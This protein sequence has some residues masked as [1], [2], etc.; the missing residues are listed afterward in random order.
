M[1]TLHDSRPELLYLS[2]VVP[3]VTGN[4]LAMRAGTVLEILAQSYSVTLLVVTLYPPFGAAV[5]EV[6]QKLC[7]RHAVIPARRH[8]WLSFLSRLASNGR[9]A[10]YS[11]LDFDVV[12]VFRLAMLPYARRYLARGPVRPARH[13]D[14]DEIESLTHTRIAGLCRANGDEMVA[15]FEEWQAQQAEVAEREAFGQYHRIYVCSE[16]DRSKISGRTRAQVC[17]LPNAVHAVSAPAA[18]EGSNLLF[19]GTLG[20][21]PNDDAARFL[22][23]EIV[24]RIREQ[25]SGV[26][27]VDIVGSGAS[28]R[29]VKAASLDS[30]VHLRG[31]VPDLEPRYRNAAAVVVPIRAG[32]G[33]RIKILEAFSYRRPVV[34]TAAGIEGIDAQ[35]EDHVL[36]GDTPDDFARHCVRLM[37]QPELG[38]RL[39]ANAWELL[40]NRYSIE[41]LKSVSF[42]RPLATE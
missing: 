36:I 33:T 15:R 24:P 21:Y 39:A 41:A 2:P 25:W 20:Y 28:S 11:R 10:L 19:V 4:G 42:L 30:S 5:P 26:F 27:Q 13:L 3:A 9:L 7:R 32:G 6:F 37:T 35:H 40:A 1:V 12:H 29:L 16:D 22:C 18:D 17:V 38:R 8:S 14:L 31:N 34:T 23:A